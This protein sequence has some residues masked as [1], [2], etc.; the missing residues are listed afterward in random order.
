MINQSEVELRAIPSPE[1]VG[2]GKRG[3]LRLEMGKRSES[4]LMRL[5]LR[6]DF[7]SEADALKKTLSMMGQGFRFEIRR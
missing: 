7:A 1:D 3:G 2:K 5:R 4:C 6:K